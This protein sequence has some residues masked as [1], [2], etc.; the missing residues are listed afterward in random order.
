MGEPEPAAAAR[1]LCSVDAVLA[2]AGSGAVWSLSGADRQLDSNIVR[3]APGG[4]IDEHLGPDLD[5]LVL[6]LAGSGTVTTAAEPLPLAP[7]TLV[8]LPRRSRRAIDAGPDGLAYLT[9][10]RRRPALTIAPGQP[11]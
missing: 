10:H 3:L 4:R 5:V 8:L 9:V 6:V 11:R 7:G 1:L 2:T